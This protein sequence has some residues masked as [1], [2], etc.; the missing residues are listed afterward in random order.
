MKKNKKMI[1]VYMLISFFIWILGIELY[2]YLKVK[3]WEFD[4]FIT[5]IFGETDKLWCFPYI[6]LLLVFLIGIVFA[7]IAVRNAG[8]KG[9]SILV[10]LLN[11]AGLLVNSVSCGMVIYN[12]SS[13]SDSKNYKSAQ[14]SESELNTVKEDEI[15]EN[16]EESEEPVFSDIS[17]Y[18]GKY[19]YFTAYSSEISEYKNNSWELAYQ[20]CVDENHK[21]VTFES[22]EEF[23]Y[24][25]K[26]LS[27]NGLEDYIFF[28]GGRKEKHYSSDNGR[29][30]HF[31]QYYYW[32]DKN[33]ELLEMQLNDTSSWMADCWE[34]GEPSVSVYDNG[35]EDSVMC[36]H[37]NEVEGKWIDMPAYFLDIY[38]EYEGKIGYIAE[39]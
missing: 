2:C 3:R 34:V 33:N 26:E 23:D 13:L 4:K 10:M 37:Y 24:V 21:L 15:Q 17:K 18:V 11:I 29:K 36:M 27:D 35:E 6:I 12:N 28:I 20:F 32:V 7:V 5:G 22:Q 38:P 8:K 31:R 9:L 14:N 25:S 1:T 30:E 16:K 19:E 39:N